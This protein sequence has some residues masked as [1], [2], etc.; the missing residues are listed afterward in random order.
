MAVQTKGRVSLTAL[1]ICHVRGHIHPPR[2]GRMG[3]F[4]SA[5]FVGRLL[6]RENN[7]L[8]FSAILS[9]SGCNVQFGDAEY[10]GERGCGLLIFLDK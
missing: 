6:M 4:P 2:H 8:D 5:V 9:I 3:G 10:S 7:P 1:L